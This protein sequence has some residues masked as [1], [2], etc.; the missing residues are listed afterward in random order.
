[1]HRARLQYMT[2]S[3]TVATPT[4]WCRIDPYDSP[5]DALE[6]SG[7]QRRQKSSNPIQVRG[8]AASGV[9]S[10]VSDVMKTQRKEGEE[11]G[12]GGGG[13]LEDRPYEDV[14]YGEVNIIMKLVQG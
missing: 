11:G 5:V 6:N 2:A 9:Y 3:Q 8:R 13:G 14:E 4:V 1:M 10:E 7:I 12:G